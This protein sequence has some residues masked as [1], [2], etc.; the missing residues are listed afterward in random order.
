MPDSKTVTINGDAHQK[1]VLTLLLSARHQLYGYIFSLVPNSADAEDIFQETSTVIWEKSGDFKQGTDFFAWAS[2][3]AFWQI[4]ASRKKFAR[5]KVIFDETVFEAV[6]KTANS[7]AEVG[8]ERRDALEVCLGKLKE[9][10]RDLLMTRYTPGC[11]V[12]EAASKCGRT[13]DAAY[14]ALGRLR[15]SLQ[16]CINRQLTRKPA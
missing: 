1:E 14:K 9:G 5:S 7:L 4:K 10:D 13:M 2:R 15:R 16:H 6:A 3:I 8:D 11:D 12:E